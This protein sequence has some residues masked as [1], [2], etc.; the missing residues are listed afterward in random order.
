MQAYVA[1]TGH[2][3]YTRMCIL[4]LL[5][6]RKCY[7]VSLFYYLLSSAV[8]ICGY[9]LSKIFLPFFSVI[10]G[11]SLAGVTTHH[12]EVSM[13]VNCSSRHLT[14]FAVLVKFNAAGTNIEVR[15]DKKSQFTSQI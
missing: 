11:W 6:T 7:I 10:G 5:W 14:S 3:R 12:S 15:V 13:V 9:S 2:H 1:Y 4:E 8:Q